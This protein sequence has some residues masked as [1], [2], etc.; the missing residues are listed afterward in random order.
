MSGWNIT[1]NGEKKVVFLWNMLTHSYSAVLTVLLFSFLWLEYWQ[2]LDDFQV[3]PSKYW[4]CTQM[5]LEIFGFRL[6]FSHQRMTMECNLY[7]NLMIWCDLQLIKLRSFIEYK[8]A[9][10]I[11]I[12]ANFV[13]YTIK[14]NSTMNFF[15]IFEKKICEH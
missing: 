10:I 15:S 14:I 2:V 1:S 13:S 7:A 12:L 11:F 6:K 3:I 8:P 9:T 4:C 5:E